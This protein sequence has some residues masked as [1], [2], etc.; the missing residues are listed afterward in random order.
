MTT[1]KLIVSPEEIAPNPTQPRHHFDAGALA[2]LGRSLRQRQRQPLTV[3]PY[4]DAGRP[5]V[6]WM[7][8]DGER[9]WRAACEAGIKKLWIIEDDEVCATDA[10]ELHTASFSTNWCRAGHTHAE[11]AAAIDREMAA[12]KSYEEIAALVGKSDTW[13][14]NEHS[15]LKLHPDVLPLLD[16]PTPKDARLPLAVALLL[17]AKFPPE[18]HAKLWAQ[19]R[20][21]GKAA[22][23]HLR[24]QT[25]HRKRAARDDVRY[26]V[27]RC[28]SAA[29]IVKSLSE[30]PNSMFAHLSAEQRQAAAAGLRA[31][32]A[33]ATN[34]ADLLLAAQAGDEET[35]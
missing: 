22:L 32:A 16:P 10:A 19:H 6:R 7:L 24:T 34:T 15:L 31:A 11:T 35:D 8:I 23:H 26:I 30:L 33:A 13:A 20:A 5:K 17:A 27:G 4:S 2:D 21:K 3:I 1:T 14:R 9:R 25:A 28:R 12:G 18:K 29:G